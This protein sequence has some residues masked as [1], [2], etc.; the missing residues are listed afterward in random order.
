MSYDRGAGRLCLT[1]D[2][3][4]LCGLLRR[5]LSSEV[6]SAGD[7]FRFVWVRGEDPP[8]GSGGDRVAGALIYGDAVD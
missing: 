3:G 7:S 1:S 5:S 4:V 6:P 8:E 2:E